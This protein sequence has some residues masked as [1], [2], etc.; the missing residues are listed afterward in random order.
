VWSHPCY[1]CCHP[2]NHPPRSCRSSPLL[3]VILLPLLLLLLLLLLFLS[4]FQAFRLSDKFMQFMANKKST[5]S[6]TAENVA[7]FKLSHA[8]ILEEIPIKIKNNELTKALLFELAKADNGAAAFEKLDLSVN[9]YLEKHVESLQDE[10]EEMITEMVK[11]H[12]YL[13][14]AQLIKQKKMKWIQERKATNRERK[15]SGLEPLV[16]G[17]LVAPRCPCMHPAT[18]FQ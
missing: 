1:C 15:K 9:P 10:L 17:G 7:Q 16:G 6:L 13:K 18:S 11:M 8:N 2:L 12:D 14:G 5:K 3:L 4:L